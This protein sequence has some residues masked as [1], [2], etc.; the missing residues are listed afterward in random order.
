[1]VDAMFASMYNLG[2]AADPKPSK[3]KSKPQPDDD[4]INNYDDIV[5]KAERRAT[6][7]EEEFQKKPSKPKKT[8]KKRKH[9]EIEV[10]DVEEEKPE[11]DDEE[12]PSAAAPATTTAL[13]PPPK[14]KHFSIQTV[15]M[16]F[17]KKAC[18]SQKK[19]DK[20]SLQEDYKL[21]Q[22]LLRDKDYPEKFDFN[23]LIELEKNTDDERKELLIEVYKRAKEEFNTDHTRYLQEKANYHDLYPHAKKLNELKRITQSKNKAEMARLL[24]GGSLTRDSIELVQMIFDILEDAENDAKIKYDAA[25]R[26]AKHR[27]REAAFKFRMTAE[28]KYKR[29]KQG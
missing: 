20:K 7:E 6:E 25:I 22:F 9:E 14:K 18:P 13:P 19:P 5:E 16:S 29:I 11:E 15:F 23:P 12:E 24:A 1:M 26:E 10:E 27:A 3:K 28:T 17:L 2:H 8:S 4:I 21:A